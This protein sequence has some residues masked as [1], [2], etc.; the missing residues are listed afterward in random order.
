MFLYT[1]NISLTNSLGK[2][3]NVTDVVIYNGAA[4]Y[5]SNLS[6][7]FLPSSGN[8]LLIKADIFSSELET[9]A[10]SPII[11]VKLADG[12]VQTLAGLTN[13]HLLCSNASVTALSPYIEGSGI[14]V[15][16]SLD[17]RIRTA[18]PLAGISREKATVEGAIQFRVSYTTPN[19]V[20]FSSFQVKWINRKNF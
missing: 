4:T 2:S 7:S 11:M 1:G 5:A 9:N 16:D 17:V 8:A 20:L 14:I 18:V 6:C 13:I 10:S 19:T 12:N 15:F 3:Q